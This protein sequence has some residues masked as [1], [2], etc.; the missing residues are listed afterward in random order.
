VGSGQVAHITGIETRSSAARLP[1]TGSGGVSPSSR[2]IRQKCDTAGKLTDIDRNK[3]RH[4]FRQRVSVARPRGPL[5][6]T[7]PSWLSRLGACPWTESRSTV[8]GGRSTPKIL[9]RYLA[10]R[11]AAIPKRDGTSSFLT[12]RTLWLTSASCCCGRD[13]DDWP[14]SQ[15]CHA[16]AEPEGHWR[17]REDT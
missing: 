16:F 5:T 3:S 9:L 6:A 12:I 11:Q 7:T 1:M 17:T 4:L 2:I 14:V 15:M 8:L 13:P 10:G